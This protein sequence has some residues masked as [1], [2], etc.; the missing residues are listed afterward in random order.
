MWDKRSSSTIGILSLLLMTFG[1]AGTAAAQVSLP[2]LGF[3]VDGD[4]IRPIWGIPGSSR[5]GKPLVLGA[6]SKAETP[7]DQQY[8]I[9]VRDADQVVIVADL[10]NTNAPGMVT[11]EGSFDHPDRLAVSPSGSAAAIFSSAAHAIQIVS[12][13]PDQPR[14]RNSFPVSTG[15]SPTA[16]AVSDDGTTILFIAAGNL[17]TAGKNGSVPF[18]GSHGTD[19]A[20][21]FLRNSQDALI[22]D[23]ATDEVLLIKA[24]EPGNQ[25]AYLYNS[26]NGIS[27]P[28]GI[29]LSKDNSRL[30]IANSGSGTVAIG[31]I[32]GGNLTVV[33]CGCQIKRFFPLA[34][35]SAFR[36]EDSSG[37]SFI[38]DAHTGV[39]SLSIVLPPSAGQ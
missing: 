17:W 15:E 28:V 21:Q 8:L 22:A 11:I 24:D 29:G 38:I 36:I 2:Q 12:G 10:R 1:N 14:I 35:D 31:N 18:G 20:I 4:A 16:L 30:F 13:L 33:S 9:G 39:A 25:K 23:K 26:R 27:A 37:T 19:L 7:L 34:L 5:T 3:K 32:S 6:V